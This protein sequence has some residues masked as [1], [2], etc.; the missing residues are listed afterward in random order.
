MHNSYAAQHALT[1]CCIRGVVQTDRH[2]F[3]D[4]IRLIQMMLAAG[5]ELVVWLDADTLVVRP[6][7]DV[8]TA[9]QDGAPIGMCRNDLPWQDLPWH[10]NAGVIFVRNTGSAR[11]F[12]DE[13]WKAGYV[14]HRAWQ[15]QAKINELARKHTD[16]VQQLDDKWNCTKGVNSVRDPIIRAWHGQGANA[17]KLMAAAVAAYKR[18]SKRLV[19][20]PSR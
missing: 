16:L 15:E 18:K 7:V 5:Y 13:V 2:P 6:E 20:Q 3:W 12:F 14:D 8:R 4:K 17:V 11:W 9:L 10:Y 19:L 1:F